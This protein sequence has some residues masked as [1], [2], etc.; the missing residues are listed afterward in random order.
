M[1]PKKLRS[2]FL[3]ATLLLHLALA[4][5]SLLHPEKDAPFVSYFDGSREDY[6]PPAGTFTPAAP[7]VTL[8]GG[9]SEHDQAMRWF[10]EAAHR[11]DVLVLRASGSDGYQE[12]LY[13]ELGVPVNS[14]ETL[15]VDTVDAANHPYVL[16]QIQHAEAVWFAGGDQWQYLRVWG[17]SE[18]KEALQTHIDQGKTIGGTSAGM[19]VLG[20]WYYT[21]ENGS[22]ISEEALQNPY[23]PLV[24]LGTGFLK[25][26]ILQNTI[27]DQHYGNRDRQ[28]RHVTFMARILQQATAA[29]T[30][31]M[32]LQVQ[33][34]DLFNGTISSIMPAPVVYG[35]ACDEY[36]AIAIDGTTGKAHV[37]GN[38]PEYPDAVYFIQSKRGCVGIDEDDSSRDPSFLP[39]VCQADQPLIWNID[40]QALRVYKI[41]GTDENNGSIHYFDLNTW[42]DAAGGEWLYWYVEDGEW[43]EREGEVPSSMQQ[44]CLM[45]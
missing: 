16:Q 14:V 9:G 29:M 32:E 33:L 35:I 24:T 6:V 7:K 30:S 21:A 27:T 18:M 34:A 43:K 17:Q 41:L 19:A 28:G 37:Y 26:P 5:D 12:Y 39:E 31:L 36:T 38:M 4:Q 22:V 1:I 15:V 2:S 20:E 13:E 11:G 45:T 42:E 44:P 25:I 3:F 8:M 40:Q 23:H 10:L